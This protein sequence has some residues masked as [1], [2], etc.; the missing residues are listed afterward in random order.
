MLL[1]IPNSPAP[2][3]Q[4]LA[5]SSSPQS[6]APSPQPLPVVL[7]D[8]SRRDLAGLARDE[9]V[10]LQWEQERAFA[11]KI[12]A[13]PKGSTLR[14]EM[15]CRAYDTVTGILAVL[16][17]TGADSLVMGL[18][19][20]QERLV[21][22]L[23]QQ[24]RRQGLDASLFEIGY[25]SGKLLK[26]V[27]QAGFPIAGIEV[28]SAMHE[29]AARLL[30]PEHRA[31]I[32]LGNFL[33]LQKPPAGNGWSLVYW[34]DV[35][36]HIP[37]DEIGDWLSH[38]HRLLIPGGKLV[39]ITPNWHVRPSDVTKA[40]RPPRTAAAGLHLKEYTLR[41]VTQLLHKAGFET[42]AA[43]LGVTS[44]RIVL[45]GNG[46]L[47]AKCFFESAL[48]WLPYGLARLACRGLGLSCTIA[49]KS[50]CR[51]SNVE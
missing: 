26:R 12:L 17:G 3:P 9:L 31:A 28:S 13:A 1:P 29:M 37:P 40:I 6:P 20:K 44:Q 2:S 19:P 35:F 14:A 34:N 27:S 16:R 51:N 30:G 7:A 5:P 47:G 4:P 46:L 10:F 39:T 45:C 21:L 50:E 36:E 42:V 43:P 38:I 49:T 48:E 15:T 33:E 25:A 8:G 22:K 18:H 32:Y 11:A 41:E 24:Q 23:L